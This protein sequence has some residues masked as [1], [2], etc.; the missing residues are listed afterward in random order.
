MRPRE[1]IGG[2]HRYVDQQFVVRAGGL[3]QHQP[4]QSF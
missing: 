1:P 4:L 3:H 2:F